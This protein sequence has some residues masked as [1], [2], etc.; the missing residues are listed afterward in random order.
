VAGFIKAQVNFIRFNQAMVALQ[1]VSG[2]TMK[3]VLRS[4]VGHILKEC[5]AKTKVA[6]E[7]VIDRKSTLGAVKKLGLT[8]AETRGQVTVNAGWRRNSPAFRVWMKVRERAG[9][10]GYILARGAGFSFPEGTATLLKS[11]GSKAGTDVWLGTVIGAVS[12]VVRA[13]PP[14]IRLGRASIGLARQSWVQIARSLRIDLKTVAGGGISAAG[15]AKAEA[16]LASDGKAYI[17]GSGR[18]YGDAKK[19]IIQLTNRLPYVRR[20]KLD[21]VLARAI[22]GRA[23]KIAKAMKDGVF[24]SAKRT[25]ARFPGLYVS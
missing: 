23:N 3:Q 8:Q 5:A 4:E 16:A 13:V 9:R 11:P 7:E 24:N 15:I 6:T 2:Q 1:R 10:K 12:S 17:N 14:A 19:V 25:L 20:A 22:N 18:E 21:A